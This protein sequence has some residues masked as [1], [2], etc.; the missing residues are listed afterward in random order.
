[1]FFADQKM[2]LTVPRVRDRAQGGEIALPTDVLPVSGADS[3]VGSPRL[4]SLA[5]GLIRRKRRTEEQIIGV[6]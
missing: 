5:G 2:P 4:P 1:V 6:L 3:Q